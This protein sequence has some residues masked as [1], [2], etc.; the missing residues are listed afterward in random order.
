M[1]NEEMQRVIAESLGYKWWKC[2]QFKAFQLRHPSV[3]KKTM[4]GKSP[5]NT[6]DECDKPADE[7]SASAYGLPNWPEDL[8]ACRR[9]FEVFLRKNQFHYVNYWDNFFTVVTGLKWTGDIGYFG[10]DLLHATAAKHCETFI[11]TVCPE[12]WIP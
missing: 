5:I 1:T 6:W 8:N 10:F 3:D 12:E 2:N 11:K 4:D 9:D 7:N